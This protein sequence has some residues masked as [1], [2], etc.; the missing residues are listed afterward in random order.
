MIIKK[1]HVQLEKLRPKISEDGKQLRNIVNNFRSGIGDIDLNTLVF[2]VESHD[3]HDIFYSVS[4][5]SQEEVDHTFRDIF[6]GCHIIDYTD[7]ENLFIEVE[8]E[9]EANYSFADELYKQL[10]HKPCTTLFEITHKQGFK[11]YYS[12]GFRAAD[13]TR[14][15][16]EIKLLNE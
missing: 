15:K 3:T 2:L 14:F 7:Q 16:A 4:F 10:E 8:S 12:N 13:R 9:H 6:I 1:T 11:D 5:S